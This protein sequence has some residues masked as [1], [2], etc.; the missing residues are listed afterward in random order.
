M[1][2][3]PIRDTLKQLAGYGMK[4]F[5]LGFFAFA[6][7]LNGIVSALSMVIAADG[8]VW[9][10]ITALLITATAILIAGTMGA[11]H[12]AIGSTLQH[13]IVKSDLVR[14]TV[15]AIFVRFGIDQNIGITRREFDNHLSEAVEK[16]RGGTS[17]E[18]KLSWIVERVRIKILNLSAASIVRIADNTFRESERVSLQTFRDGA[19]DRINTHIST[20]IKRGVIAY[21]STIIAVGTCVAFGISLMI[22]LM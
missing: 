9:K 8:A 6:I 10:P 1:I 7:V 11:I 13:G 15:N 12:F 20:T 21:C 17:A 5:Y 22:R 19:A 14:V 3:Q 16:L 4:K 2:Q 18:E